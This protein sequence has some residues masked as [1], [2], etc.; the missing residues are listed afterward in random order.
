MTSKKVR[1]EWDKYN[2]I[3][4]WTKHKVRP[5]EAEQTFSDTF[6]LILHDELHS[7]LEARHVVIGK[8]KKHRILSIVFTIR[9]LRI[10]V[11]SVRDANKKEVSIYEKEISGT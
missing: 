7:Q 11:I 6:A 8:T 9:K 2:T 10:R 4:N 1:F 3:K 5:F